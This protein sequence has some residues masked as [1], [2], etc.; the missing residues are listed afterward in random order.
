[1]KPTSLRFVILAATLMLCI[2]A[3]RPRPASAA[4]CPPSS[5]AVVFADCAEPP[6]LFAGDTQVGTCTEGGAMHKL[7]VVLCTCFTT[8]CYE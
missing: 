1:M 6:C 3:Q 2:V 8:E 7:L 4:A 5:C